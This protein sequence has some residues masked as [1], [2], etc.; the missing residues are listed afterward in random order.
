VGLYLD[1]QG[2]CFAVLNQINDYGN[3]SFGGAPLPVHIN[4]LY[5]NTIN[6]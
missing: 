6:L 5:W 1:M 3:N 2:G 4:L